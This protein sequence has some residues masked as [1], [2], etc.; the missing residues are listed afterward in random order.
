M[1]EQQQLTT[2][3]T[4]QH[5][6]IR[7]VWPQCPELYRSIGNMLQQQWQRRLTVLTV[8]EENAEPNLESPVGAASSASC[9]NGAFPHAAVGLSQAWQAP[10]VALQLLI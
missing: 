6:S 4:A 8:A 3:S 1:H 5:S 2:S 7:T 10:L 9:L